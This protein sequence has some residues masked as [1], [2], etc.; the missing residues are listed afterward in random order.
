MGRPGTG[1]LSAAVL[2]ARTWRE[3]G[4]T[5]AATHLDALGLIFLCLGHQDLQHAV[6]RRGFDLVRHNMAG[7][8][9][10][11]AE[12][13]VAAL[14]AVDLLP[15]GVVCG[16][17][18][19][20]DRQQAVLER[21]I[22]VAGL[23][24]G[25]IGR[26]QVGVSLRSEISTAGAQAAVL[27]AP[28]CCWPE[29]QVRPAFIRIIS[30]CAALRSSNKSQLVTT[31]IRFSLVHLAGP[32]ARRPRK[33]TAR[34][35]TIRFRATPFIAGLLRARDPLSPHSLA[36]AEA[37]LAPLHTA[38]LPQRQT[39]RGFR[40]IYD[41]TIGFAL[42]DRTTASEQRVQD[43]ATRRDLHAFVRSLP[44]DRFPVLAA[45]GEYVWADD[46]DEQ[47][48]ASLDTLINGLQAAQR[49]H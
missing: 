20:L 3:R 15:R 10:R 1:L 5:L 33:N 46:R 32:V 21:D 34:V 8:R 24:A 16:V 26:N 47:F 41:Y 6:L 13:A 35:N 40:L 39:A 22:H 45:L 30:S 19:A 23:D 7:Q 37:F 49:R 42:S 31:V 4:T 18:L 38:G 29:R 48:T 9:D 2:G 36:L 25:E 27:V 12:G 17:P 28:S 14:A 11:A 44:A 43:A